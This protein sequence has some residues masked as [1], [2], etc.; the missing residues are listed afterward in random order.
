M[1][2]LQARG[3]YALR[4]VTALIGLSP[5]QVRSYV[6]AGIV[7]PERGPRGETFSFQDLILLKTAKALIE[8]RI[9]RPRIHAAL[10]NLRRQ[11]PIERPLSGV[12]IAAQ[13][14]R[15]VV[16]DGAELW[17][18][19]SGQSMLDFEVDGL[20]REASAISS[21]RVEATVAEEPDPDTADGWFFRGVESE[22][23]DE[24]GSVTDPDGAAAVAYLRALA[25]APAMADAHLNLGRLLHGQGRLGE[26]EERYRLALAGAADGATAATSAFNLG[27]ALQ[28]Q[29][30]LGEAA[31]AYLEALSRDGELADGH[32]NLATVY[33]ALGERAAAFRHFKTY[34]ALTS[35]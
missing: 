26:A 1:E 30:R 25:L 2:L 21:R 19:E 28:D 20:R 4:D 5:A 3:G 17:N 18:P 32:Y 6:R 27:V 33:E 16:R 7:A 29:G 34:R 15:V 10:K 9:P 23:V 24:D 14:G 13:G 12:R 22:R 31:E 8:A 11:L 35:G